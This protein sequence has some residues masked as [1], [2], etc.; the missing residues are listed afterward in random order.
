MSG[1]RK[2]C[3]KIQ[4]CCQNQTLLIFPYKLHMPTVGVR[5]EINLR[6][7]RKHQE[8]L[9]IQKRMCESRISD[10]HS[11]RVFSVFHQTVIQFE[12]FKYKQRE[13]YIKPSQY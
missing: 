3:N 6:H 12:I 10:S 1:E 11:F 5:W 7:I 4:L 8:K 13:F 2:L 9:D